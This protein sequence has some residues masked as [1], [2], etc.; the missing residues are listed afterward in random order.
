MPRGA[1]APSGSV[2]LWFQTTGNPG[3]VACTIENKNVTDA[4]AVN[5][6]ACKRP[7]SLDC[8]PHADGAV[9]Q[10]CDLSKYVGKVMGFDCQID[11]GAPDRLQAAFLAG[12]RCSQRWRCAP[13]SSALYTIS[14]R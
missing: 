8:V 9:F 12:L 13:A 5:T 4:D 10:G 11:G 3:N 2:S 6:T 7:F 1:P 14:F